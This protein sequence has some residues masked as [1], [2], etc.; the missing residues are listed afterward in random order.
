MLKM[1]GGNIN[2]MASRMAMNAMIK[3]VD[4]FL[5]AGMRF[6]IALARSLANKVW[7]LAKVLSPGK[8][9]QILDMM[10]GITN[11]LKQVGGIQGG[12]PSRRRSKK[13]HLQK[14]K[15]SIRGKSKRKTM[16]RTR[17]RRGGMEHPSAPPSL[18]RNNAVPVPY[19]EMITRQGAQ[20]KAEVERA[21]AAAAAQKP[22]G[23]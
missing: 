21:R 15:K 9:R 23:K 19:H 18:R 12:R 17:R 11:Q 14:H 4:V 22:V 2:D 3:L 10:E 16:K 1:Q 8:I 7:W 5:G 6:Q 20:R 13:K